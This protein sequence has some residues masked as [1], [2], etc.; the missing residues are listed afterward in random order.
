VVGRIRRRERRDACTLWYFGGGGVP[1]RAGEPKTRP[2]GGSSRAWRRLVE[3]YRQW[4][5]VDNQQRRPTLDVQHQPDASP[6]SEI[7]RAFAAEL[8]TRAKPTRYNRA[9]KPTS[10]R[11][12][13]CSSWL[14]VA[15]SRVANPRPAQ[16]APTAIR[17]RHQHAKRTDGGGTSC[18]SRLS[19]ISTDQ[20]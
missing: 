2:R 17:Y 18:P 5:A 4:A 16:S 8:Q 7:G 6:Q 10:C 12:R 14:P 3:D 9:I 11:R 20:L 13:D 15:S 19:G 1:L